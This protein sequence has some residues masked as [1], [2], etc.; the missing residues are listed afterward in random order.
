MD[1][2]FDILN[3]VYNFPKT[4]LDVFKKD[5]NLKSININDKSLKSK[6]KILKEAGIKN[7]NQFETI[8]NMKLEESLKLTPHEDII[9]LGMFEDWSKNDEYKKNGINVQFGNE[10]GIKFG[11]IKEYILKFLDSLQDVEN[12]YFKFAVEREDGINWTT[13][14]LN[15][16]N[17]V[18]VNKLLNNE[19]IEE[20]FNPAE[21]G[22]Q[23]I[24]ETSDANVVYFNNFVNNNQLSHII[25]SSR[26]NPENSEIKVYADNS[27]AFY[28]SKLKDEFKSLEDITSR[29]QIF[30][31]LVKDGVARE[32]FNYNCLTY[33]FMKSGIF[34]HDT[35][36]SI[37][38]KC[39]TR[40]ISRKVLDQ[41]CKQYGIK[42]FVYKFQDDQWDSIVRKS[43][44]RFLG[45]KYGTNEIQLGLI[46]KHYF[47]KEDIKGIST[48]YLKHFDEI[49]KYCIENEK[50][51]TWGRKVY[52][53]TDDGEYKI[54]A[55]KAHMDSTTF[56]NL[57]EELNMTEKL[58]FSERAVMQTD[59]YKYVSEDID[60]ISL[61]EEDFKEIC[62]E[63][64]LEKEYR[65]VIK[66]AEV[67]CCL[68]YDEAN[69]SK[70]IEI[71]CP[72]CNWI[73]NLFESLN[74]NTRISFEEV[75]KS[76]VL[77]CYLKKGSKNTIEYNGKIFK[78]ENK[79][80]YY[81]DCESDTMYEL[82]NKKQ[83][84]KETKESKFKRVHKAF[85]ISYT[86][87][88]SNKIECIFGKDCIEKFFNI[89]ENNSIVYFH[90]LGYDSRLMNNFKI[91]NA[92]DKGSRIMTETII[93]NDKKIHLKDS[94]ALISTKLEKFNSMFKLNQDI[95]KEMFPYNYY[96]I[97]RLESN[98]GSIK[99]AGNNELKWNQ[100]Q[101]EENIIKCNA[102]IDEDHFDMKRYC[103][104]YCNQ[105]VNILSKGF[106]KFREWCLQ[107][108]IYIDVDDIISS[109]SLAN[110]YY[111][112]QVYSKCKNYYKIGGIPRAF[113]QKAVYGGRC[114]L[115]QNKKWHIVKE[116]VD[117]DAVSLYPSA[118][119]R[120]YLCSGKPIILTQEELNREYLFKNTA[121]ENDQVS[122]EKPIAAYIVEIDIT[123][124][125]KKLDFPLIC[126]RDP[127]S[128]TN[129]NV[130]ECCKMFV[131]N[132]V[133]EDLVKYQEIEFNVVQGY[134]WIGKKDFSIRTEIQTLHELRGKFKSEKNAM[135]EIIK[136]IMNSGYGKCIQKPIKTET[137]Y[138]QVNG[139]FK[140]YKAT[141]LKKYP[142]NI[143][144]DVKGKKY[145]EVKTT[146]LESYCKK[147]HAKIN[148]IFE[149][150]NNLS[151]VVVNKQI[152]DYYT[153][154]VFGV[155]VLSMSKRIMNEVMT[156]AEDLKIDI[157]Y[158]DTDSMHIDKSKLELLS[159]T[160]KKIYGRELIGDKVLGQFHSDFEKINETDKET[161]Y[162]TESYFLGKKCYI[163]HLRNNNGDR[164]YHYRMKGVDLKC[165]KLVADRDFNGELLK[166]YKHLFDNNTIE[167]DLKLTLPCFEMNKNRTVVSRKD[168]KRNIKFVGD[169]HSVIKF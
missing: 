150:N 166:V 60:K 92:I 64:K 49:N 84:E 169:K 127:K 119:A 79:N 120:L 111:T 95:Q 167:F 39:F 44:K 168:F 154:P 15:S 11:N 55:A 76:S 10:T 91:Q 132:I 98:I 99:E 4:Y 23:H 87:R 144:T 38:T 130:N 103:E 8:Y 43:K 129:K 12:W 164:N 73:T 152:D 118:M 156:L 1:M 157:F 160:F 121:S 112:R 61:V 33:A 41:I 50:S 2:E 83:E 3:F 85:C 141:D 143:K 21:K 18:I 139:V 58:T 162:A 63:S 78:V 163:D 16:E 104:F 109:A 94:Y 151:G 34:F 140:S 158:Q 137:Q 147:N 5:G 51:L 117:F 54:N 149:I 105:D 101:F 159:E 145:I 57:L 14:P 6:I 134:K 77:S 113:I 115:K 122:N 116:L 71:K 123:K 81:A 107:F 155:Q 88:G 146:P 17:I 27:G 128:G 25:I 106:D 62:S 66:K 86:K 53:K 70:I 68:Y 135:Q 35:L 65:I 36:K 52:R 102:K 47:L 82:T 100:K 114:M 20:Y 9:D 89:V 142:N 28:D 80:V 161:P 72:N 108:P 67:H 46:R 32:E 69:P 48:Y 74:T 165:V 131:D 97:E 136:L 90:N 133:L 22:E 153:N 125:G 59:L 31:I 24:I 7:K 75:E 124:V 13:L 40:I 110:K 93:Y 19:S 45:D 37:M 42:C 126:Y 138:K 56:I 29:Y 26:L 148:Q 96:T 30:N